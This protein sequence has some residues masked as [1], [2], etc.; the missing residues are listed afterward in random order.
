ML[1][2]M[3]H[4][5]GCDG[6][7]TLVPVSGSAIHAIFNELNAF[8]GNST[9]VSAVID[10]KEVQPIRDHVAGVRLQELQRLQFLC[11]RVLI[12]SVEV[13]SFVPSWAPL[14]GSIS[15][16]SMQTYWESSCPTRTGGW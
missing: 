6:A 10:G 5:S 2:L 15:S 1:P 13:S 12:Y 4:M 16:C 11:G 8:V 14:R 7:R 3:A 9:G